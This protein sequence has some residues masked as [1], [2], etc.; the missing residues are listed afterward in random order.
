MN[1]RDCSVDD[2]KVETPHQIIE[3]AIVRELVSRSQLGLESERVC[4]ATLGVEED[5]KVSGKKKKRVVWCLCCINRADS[6][7][8]ST[9]HGGWCR[10][11]R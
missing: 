11:R 8:F 7:G 3:K 2:I 9:E 4:Q 5:K 1:L 10:S 6:L